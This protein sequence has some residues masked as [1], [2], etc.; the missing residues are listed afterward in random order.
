MVPASPLFIGWDTAIFLDTREPAL[1]YRGH[2]NSI[3]II[4]CVIWHPTALVSTRYHLNSIGTWPFNSAPRAPSFHGV[5]HISS[6]FFAAW[7]EDGVFCLS[8][9][10]VASR[11][12]ALRNGTWRLMGPGDNFAS[13]GGK[14]RRCSTHS[15][16]GPR[17]RQ[18]VPN[19][20]GNRNLVTWVGTYDHSAR[21]L[22]PSPLGH[23]FGRPA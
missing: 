12:I 14:N 20:R 4:F 10:R 6:V 3:A 16:C 17:D 1:T 15:P 22:R 23:Q 2:L 19:S 21:S 5:T 9:V 8:G 18:D 11:D 7:P 13:R